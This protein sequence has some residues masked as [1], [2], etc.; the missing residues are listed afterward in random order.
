MSL[1][2]APTGASAI[3]AWDYVLD[4]GI[5]I[6]AWTSVS[7]VGID[8]ITV[9]ARVVVASIHTYLTYAG[10]VAEL[11]PVSRPAIGRADA[12]LDHTRA[13]EEQLQR[14]RDQMGNSRF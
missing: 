7:V 3:D 14:V 10:A 2:R 8:L 13:L 12:R 6:D 5:V 1:Q 4:K 11:S 9:E